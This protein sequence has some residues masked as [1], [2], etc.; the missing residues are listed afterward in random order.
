[1]DTLIDY[2]KWMS[3]IPLAATGVREPDA[4]VLCA[5]SY[6]DMAPVFAGKSSSKHQVRECLSMVDA[7]NVRV[8]ITADSEDY[9]K[10]LAAAAASRRF[11]QL[12]MSDYTDVLRQDPPLQFSA[13]CFSDDTDISFIA[14]RGTD[15]S[16]A[17]WEEDFMISF[18]RTDAQAM[19]LKY[20]EKLIKPGR[21]WYIGGHSKGGNLALYAACML[22]QKKWLCVDRMYLL[23]GPGFCPEVL[24]LNTIPHIDAKTTRIIPRFSVVGRLYEPRITDTRIVKS[25]KSGFTQHSIISWG[26]DHGGLCTVKTN[27]PASSLVVEVLMKWVSDIPL[28]GRGTFVEELFDAVTAGGAATLEDLTSGGPSGLEAI[29]RKLAASSNLTKKSLQ[30]LPAYAWRSSLDNIRQMITT[31][32]PIGR[33]KG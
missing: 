33:D 28:E 26:I 24:D 20:A 3:D 11:G 25:S 31:E 18:T 1:M 10:L 9:P 5:M 23:D 21:R 14:Y 15:S 7:G 13:V 17:G 16:L 29:I 2:I 30:E 6:I 19:A 4:L 12:I 27:E 22:H 32:L 8:M